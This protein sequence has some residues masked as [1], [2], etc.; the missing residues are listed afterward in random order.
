MTIEPF[1]EAAF[2][3]PSD[4]DA[5]SPPYDWRLYRVVARVVWADNQSIAADTLR[6]L[7][8]E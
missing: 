8:S 4:P 2:A 1:D 6:L 5:K 3:A 7:R